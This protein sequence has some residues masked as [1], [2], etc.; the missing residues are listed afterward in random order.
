MNERDSKQTNRQTESQ[1]DREPDR[2]LHTRKRQLE[3]PP[4]ASL[5]PPM[6][7]QNWKCRWKTTAK[8][9]QNLRKKNKNKKTLLW[10]ILGHENHSLLRV[11]DRLSGRARERSE[12]CRVSERSERTDKR[13]TH[14][15]HP[16]LRPI[17]TAMHRRNT[18]FLIFVSASHCIC[19]FFATPAGLQK[20][21]FHRTLTR[22][23]RSPH[24][25]ACLFVAAVFRCAFAFPLTVAKKI[26]SYSELD[27]KSLI[28]YIHEG[29]IEYDLSDLAI[30]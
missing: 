10:S 24:S 26:S 1:A 4:A 13:V 18:T 27:L 14:Y 21:C 5:Q 12:Q 17:E 3:P 28:Q 22:C 6:K 16:E 30:I 23:E 2:Q 25:C 15:S 19:F 11:W 29:W 7:I 8:K 9:K 20:S